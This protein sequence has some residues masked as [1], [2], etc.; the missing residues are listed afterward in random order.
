MPH[1]SPSIRATVVDAEAIDSTDEMAVMPIKVMVTPMMAPRMGMP[2]AAKAPKTTI[3][4]M[5]AMIRPISSGRS[6]TFGRQPG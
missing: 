4:T 6:E 1:D 3:N 5:N 2:A